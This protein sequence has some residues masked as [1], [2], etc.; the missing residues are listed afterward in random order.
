MA[1]SPSFTSPNGN[2]ATVGNL[3]KER[4]PPTPARASPPHQPATPAPTLCDHGTV[5][6]RGALW[7]LVSTVWAIPLSTHGGGRSLVVSG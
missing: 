6:L 5:A 1:T 2:I 7:R 4:M 3:Q